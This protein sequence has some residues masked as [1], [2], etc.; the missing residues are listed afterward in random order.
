M[1]SELVIARGWDW[2]VF[3]FLDQIALMAAL[4]FFTFAKNP[5]SLSLRHHD[6]GFLVSSL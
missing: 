6:V 1:P 5:K 4:V 3:V 2:A